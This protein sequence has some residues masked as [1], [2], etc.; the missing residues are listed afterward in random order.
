M[1]TFLRQRKM[2]NYGIYRLPM[3][4]S[5]LGI[6][7]FGFVKFYLRTL[8]FTNGFIKFLLGIYPN[9]IAGLI[10]PMLFLFKY[11]SIPLNKVKSFDIKIKLI[12]LISTSFL[13]FEEFRP[14]FASSKTFDYWD[15]IFSVIGSLLFLLIY[16]KIKN[17][18]IRQQNNPILQNDRKRIC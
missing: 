9:F 6:L 10:I 17:K 8:H 4:V 16:Q 18:K 11:Q 15:I 13:I 12:V 3:I 7:L 14:T 5:V 1:I 2:N